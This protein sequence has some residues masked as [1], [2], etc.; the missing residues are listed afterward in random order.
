MKRIVL[1]GGP[2]SG[3]TTALRYVSEKL[4]ALGYSVICVPEAATFVINSGISPDSL[5][6]TRSRKKYLQLEEM[7][8]KTQLLFEDK[9]FAELAKIKDQDK[10]IMLLD[11]GCMDMS[12]YVK[13]EEF[14][15]IL[16][17]NK[18]NV[19]GLR[20]KRY[21]A[22]FHLVTVADGKKE[23]YTKA[24]NAARYE[25]VEEAMAAD[26][27]TQAA[28]LGH[29]HLW[30]IDNSTLFE[31]KMKRLLE[32]IKKALGVPTSLEIERKFLV[33]KNFLLKYPIPVPYQKISIEQAYL[34]NSGGKEW[35]IRRR[36]QYG[37]SVY[38][39]TSKKWLARGGVREEMEEQISRK[40][41]R[42][43]MAR[44][45]TR[46]NVIKKDRVCFV[47]GNHYF[48]MDFFLDPECGYGIVLLEVELTHKNEKVEMPEWLGPITEVTDMPEYTN[49]ALSSK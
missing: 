45:D 10:V 6:S 37:K 26:K 8:V 12:A 35:R 18:W 17:K 24:N 20:D 47:H 29:P 30:I 34:K 28:W 14:K 22:V 33:H 5:L 9:I 44:R 36:S 11:R 25:S 31:A 42:E 16:R 4:T 7:M 23:F 41:Y 32:A 49:Y 3:K 2:C 43:L 21:D 48:E 46:R 13:P 15:M 39:K 38:W 19:V 27:R 40:E 1:T